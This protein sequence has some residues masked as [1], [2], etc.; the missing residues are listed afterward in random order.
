MCFRI[1]FLSKFANY[2]GHLGVIM[3]KQHWHFT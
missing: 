1:I 3:N 2:I